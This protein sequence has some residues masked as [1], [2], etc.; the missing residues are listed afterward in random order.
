MFEA[1]TRGGPWD[2][3]YEVGVKT[4]VPG[5]YTGG[6]N[7]MIPRFVVLTHYPTRVCRTDRRTDEHAA[8]H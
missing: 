4:R 5:L 6:E 1:L 8:Y 2:L 7:R 3:G